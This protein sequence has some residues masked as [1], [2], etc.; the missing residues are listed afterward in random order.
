MVMLGTVLW[1][2]LVAQAEG[3]SVVVGGKS[4][5]TWCKESHH[6]VFKIVLR[7]Q[8]SIRTQTLINIKVAN[9]LS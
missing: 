1:T 6:H 2:M 8:K 3:R 4:R 9:L 5:A 7:A